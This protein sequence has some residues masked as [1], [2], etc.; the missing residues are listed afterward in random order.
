MIN[1]QHTKRSKKKVVAN[2]QFTFKMIHI[3]FFVTCAAR[4]KFRFLYFCFN[5]NAKI[6]DFSFSVFIDSFTD[7]DIPFINLIWWGDADGCNRFFF[8]FFRTKT[9]DFFI[10]IMSAISMHLHLSDFIGNYKNSFDKILCR[11]CGD[12]IQELCIKME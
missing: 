9:S 2:F 3:N 12:N 8:F 4:T 10:F 1:N 11:P 5:R 6:N 7:F